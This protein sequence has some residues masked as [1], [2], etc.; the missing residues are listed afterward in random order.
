[1]FV[2]VCNVCVIVCVCVCNMY[3]FV[4]ESVWVRV[5]HK[6]CRVFERRFPDTFSDRERDRDREREGEIVVVVN[7]L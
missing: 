7:L 4:C 6:Y 5:R 1:M 2:C 3:V